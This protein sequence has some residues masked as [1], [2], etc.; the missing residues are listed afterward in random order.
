MPNQDHTITCPHCNRLIPVA[1]TLAHQTEARLQQEFA[2]KLERE[3]KVLEQQFSGALQAKLREEMGAELEKLKK[4][5]AAHKADHAKLKL[6]EM[7]LLEQEQ[8][9]HNLRADL[10]LELARKL[11][12]EREK[13]EE[14]I[15]LRE[16]ERS[17]MRIREYEK[18]LA[19]QKKL[20]DEMRRKSEQGS[21]QLQGE[22]QELALEEWLQQTFPLD[23]IEEVRKGASGA[24]AI[25]VVRNPLGR[26]C[27]SILYESKRTKSFSEAWLEKLREDLRRQGADLAV[28]VTEAMPKDMAH[29]GLR[30]GIWVC[31]FSEVKALAPVLRDMLVRVA[32]VE[33]AQVN[34]GE[35]M[36]LLY[37]FLT[38]PEFY[39]QV[40]AIVE[41]FV[42]MREDLDKEKR[43]MQRHW[44]MREKQIEKVIT[45]TVEMYGAV[46]GI[47][48]QA[49][50]G[51]PAL[52]L[53]GGT[54]P[55]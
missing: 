30:Q 32:H 24:D 4:E 11:S 45:N 5:N 21:M 27:G 41:G 53:P 6:K 46:Q 17:D 39:R 10:D 13:L 9:I 51:I 31:T 34:K 14:K 18:Q 1:E 19:D 36:A 16:Q 43:A 28:I 3:R 20:I 2:A 50:R 49:V 25:Q 55:D 22:V 37:D 38:G 52:G 47:A 33:A 54:E 48:G 44:K 35:K 23:R 8:Q 7:H 42:A 12:Q 15:A 40:E 29:F 26:E